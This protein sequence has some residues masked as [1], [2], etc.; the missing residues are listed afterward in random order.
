[1]ILI[2]TAFVALTLA[3]YLYHV[4]HGM[5]LVPDEALKFSPHRWTVEGIKKAYERNTDSSVDVTQ[6]LPPKQNRRY[7]VVGGSGN[8]LFLE[9]KSMILTTAGLVGNWIVTHLLARGENPAAIRILDL[10]PPRKGVLDQGAVFIKT[11]I[12][13]KTAVSNA[14]TQPWPSKEIEQLPLTI[15]HTAAVIRPAERHKA[16][17]H[18]CTT[19]NVGGTRNVLEAAKAAGASCFI[20][21]SSGSVGLRRASFW[22]PPWINAPKRLVQVLSDRASDQPKEHDKFF[23]NYAVS[24][25]QAENLVRGADSAESGFRT[26]CIR[27]ANGIYGIGADGSGSILGLY[28]RSSGNPT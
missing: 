1:M 24:K 4:N 27:P 10:Q 11:N 22:I 23:G 18:L 7:V 3:L 21:T 19:V 15:Y 9:K 25:Y 16:L 12:T 5:T 2:V 28:L 6:H 13:D 14:F 26:G 20:A 17:L 8:Y